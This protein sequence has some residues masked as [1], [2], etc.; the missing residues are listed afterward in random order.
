MKI[1]L[2]AAT[3][4]E[5]K[6]FIN[7]HSSKHQIDCIVHSVGIMASTFNLQKICLQHYDI[8]IQIGLAGSYN[9]I[10]QIGEVVFVK[11]EQLG[12][13]GAEDNMQFL[14]MEDLQLT[15]PDEFPFTNNIL[16]NNYTNTYV[17]NI[18]NVHGITVHTCAGNEKTIQLR[19]HKYKPDIETMEGACLH[20]VC[21]Q[22][23]IPCI[24]LRAISNM[25]EIRN[26]ENWNIPLALQTLQQHTIDLINTF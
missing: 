9:N 11:T 18:K 8:I 12:D 7:I 13:F 25:V 3:E 6:P 20:Y 5:I 16:I 26:K 22:H 1:A 15:N 10:I 4:I 23:N 14:G 17:Q 21:L 2:V 24:Q 19:K